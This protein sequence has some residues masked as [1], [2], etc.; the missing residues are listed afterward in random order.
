MRKAIAVVV[1]IILALL[2]SSV[3]VVQQYEKGIIL[4]FAKVVRDAENKPVVYEPGLH[5]KIPF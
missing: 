3:F 1:V 2:Y 4:R 5:F